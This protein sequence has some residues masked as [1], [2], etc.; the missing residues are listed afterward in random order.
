L[1]ALDGDPLKDVNELNKVRFVMKG[2]TVVRDE[3]HA[4]RP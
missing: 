3:F 2:G 4:A 1:I